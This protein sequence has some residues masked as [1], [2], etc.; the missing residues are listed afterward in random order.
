[1][2]NQ[3]ILISIITTLS[4]LNCTNSTPIT[5][6]EEMEEMETEHNCPDSIGFCC[7]MDYLPLI[8]IPQI[9]IGEQIW[10]S[11]NLATYTSN[12]SY[13]YDF[14]C[15]YADR[16]R[17]YYWSIAMNDEEP[18]NPVQQKVQGICP[19][20]WHIPSMEEWEI[21]CDYLDSNQLNANDLKSTDTLLWGTSQLGTNSTGFNALPSG[22]YWRGTSQATLHEFDF[23]E[24]NVV[25]W[26]STT[27]SQGH[28][29]AIEIAVDE[30]L[31]KKLSAVGNARSLRCLKD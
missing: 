30:Q 28:P 12:G 10:M 23:I 29:M 1:M 8:E 25:Y 27:N 9:Q 6:M 13:Y 19:D 18:P 5:E 17:L 20:G 22:T 7:N 4:L 15:E 24:K 26:A 3:I 14:N 31:V 2:K 21:L 11:Q 16:G